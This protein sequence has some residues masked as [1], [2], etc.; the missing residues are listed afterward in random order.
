MPVVATPHTNNDTAL[1]ALTDFALVTTLVIV[2]Q[3][4]STYNNISFVC[5]HS[6]EGLV[7]GSNTG[8]Q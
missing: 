3:T 6:T 1:C 4:F 8:T 7:L 2:H 5:D